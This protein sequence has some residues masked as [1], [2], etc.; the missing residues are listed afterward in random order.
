M[1]RLLAVSAHKVCCR[2]QFRS[3][4]EEYNAHNN[5]MLVAFK[6]LL[7]LV[8]ACIVTAVI[9]VHWFFVGRCVC[10]CVLGGGG[11]TGVDGELKDTAGC[12]VCSFQY[13]F[14]KICSRSTQKNIVN[15]LC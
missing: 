2:Y 10:V 4:T 3:D 14:V 1:I 5:V 13:R 6:L 12:F 9:I 7:L 8:H 15:F 11:V